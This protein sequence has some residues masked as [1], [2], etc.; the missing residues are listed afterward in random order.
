MRRASRSCDPS[1]VAG[2]HLQRFWGLEVRLF[3]A[4]QSVGFKIE[5]GAGDMFV[6]GYVPC[7][8]RSRVIIMVVSAALLIV[9]VVVLVGRR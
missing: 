3:L 5:E 9:S 1:D 8:T 2:G 4:V 7:S 6:C